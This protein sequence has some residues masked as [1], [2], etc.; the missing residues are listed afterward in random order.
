MKTRIQ[1]LVLSVIALLVTLGI[2]PQTCTATPT[3]VISGDSPD[4][5]SV[6]VRGGPIDVG[7]TIDLRL[8]T[9]W[10]VF[11]TIVEDARSFKDVLTISGQA[12]HR[13]G[14]HG[15]ASNAANPFNFSFTVDTDG[16]GAG[17]HIRPNQS[18][19]VGHGQHF[20]QFTASLSFSVTENFI[21]QR[22]ITFYNFRLFGEHT[23]PSQPIGDAPVP[24]PAT[25]L[26]LGTGLTGVAIKMRKRLK[27]RKSG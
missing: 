13:T 12:F 17:T 23:V 10:T 18:L 20:D 7:F 14:P 22:N 21:G 19:I 26:L 27:S 5:L 6:T 16:F 1:M 24:E 8:G 2:A 9:D 3:T 25:L 11:A 15:E 4:L